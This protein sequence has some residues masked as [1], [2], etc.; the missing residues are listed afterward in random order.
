MY[1]VLYGFLLFPAKNGFTFIDDHT[2]LSWVYLLK[3]KSEVEE[4]FKIFFQGTIKVFRSDNGQEY[5]NK[6]LG[7]L[8]SEKGIVHQSSCNDTPQRNGVAE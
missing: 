3:E 5:F 6:I 7:H 8:F 2:R 4:I 1:G